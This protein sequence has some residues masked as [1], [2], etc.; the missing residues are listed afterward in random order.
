MGGLKERAE[1][2]EDS[3]PPI[4]GALP[5]IND[6]LS[7]TQASCPTPRMSWRHREL[8]TA[9]PPE[10]LRVADFVGRHPG[11]AGSCSDRSHYEFFA[12]VT[13]DDEGQCNRIAK[14]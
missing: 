1:G 11:R 3:L 12:Q 5:A 10:K 7:I 14:Q 2:A 13:K 6:R 9:R 8:A 4:S